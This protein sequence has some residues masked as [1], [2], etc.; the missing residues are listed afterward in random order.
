MVCPVITTGAVIW[1][2]TGAVIDHNRQDNRTRELSRTVIPA[3]QRDSPYHG[4][5]L[6][7]TLLTAR[8]D[9]RSGHG[10]GLRLSCGTLVFRGPEDACI[11]GQR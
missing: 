5:N 4:T 10:D 1:M 6:F 2:V 3:R 8:E 7:L 9:D 11:R